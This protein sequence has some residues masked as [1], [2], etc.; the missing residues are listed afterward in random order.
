[1]GASDPP[2]E[3]ER[4]RSESR[5]LNEQVKQLVR[6]ERRLSVSQQIQERQLH[7]VQV[8]SGLAL[9]ASRSDDVAVI[10]GLAAEALLSLFPYEQALGMVVDEHGCLTPTIDRAVAGRAATTYICS[11][12]A[13][14]DG[15]PFDGPLLGSAAEIRANH[16]DLGA[17]IGCFEAAFSDDGG[18]NADVALLL[19]PVLSRRRELRALLALRRVS[20]LL[21]FFE[22][23]P[24]PEDVPF[25][26]LIAA[27]VGS[28][29]QN[30]ELFQATQR[31][32]L[33]NERLYRE[34]QE[35]IRHRDEFLSIASHELRTPIA[36]LQLQLRLLRKEASLQESGRARVEAIDRQGE[37]LATLVDQLLDVARIRV[38]RMNPQLAEVDLAAVMR[39]TLGRYRDEVARAGCTIMLSAPASV[40]VLVDPAQIGQV[41][42][43]LLANALKFAPGKPIEVELTATPE[44]ARLRVRDHGIGV[45][46]EDQ[47]RVFDR[48]ERAVSSRQFGGLGLGLY[49]SRQIVEA[50]GGSL[51]VESRP[52]EGATFT[53]ELPVRLG[54]RPTT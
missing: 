44:R 28:A 5:D 8:L 27:H 23:L 49:I 16:P 54:E 46:A 51:T 11:P 3:L 4:L 40:R 25:L 37:R 52:G 12:A 20:S 36:S 26:R 7:R 13:L 33:E 41:F 10:L 31:S 21:S 53:V 34:A 39:E 1:M 18:P 6:A 48:F 19:L 17:V 30:V 32:A 24:E 22:R 50:H 15:A 42:A 29:V 47:A 35:A 43:N 38:G 14:P 45:P 9:E 2:D